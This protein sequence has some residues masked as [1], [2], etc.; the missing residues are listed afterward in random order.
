MHDVHLSVALV[1]LDHRCNKKW[2]LAHDGIGCCLATRK[3]KLSGIIVSS[4]PEFYYQWAMEKCGVLQ[5]GSNNIKNCANSVLYRCRTLTE[6]HIRQ[7][8]LYRPKL[9]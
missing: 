9:R 5:F 1:D 6:N 7:I 2:K 8:Q 4:D 3:K